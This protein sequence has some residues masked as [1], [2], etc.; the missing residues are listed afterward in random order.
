[1]PRKFLIGQLACFGDCLYA[2]TIAKQIKKD[3]PDSH[4]TWAVASKYRSILELN[5]F[6][7]AIWE[8]P[9]NNGD[10]YDD[11]WDKFEA[12]ALERKQKGEFDEIIFSQVI[13]NNLL[14]YQGT[15][16]GTI[17]AA[18]GRPITV[19]KEPVLRLSE[20]EVNN[21][22]V[23]AEKSNIKRYKHVVLFECDAG[24]GQSK[25]NLEHALKI[26]KYICAANKDVCFIIS[27]SK[28]LGDVAPQIIDASSLTYRENAELT[29]YCTL[30]VGC[31]S[32]IT[33]IST[34]DWAKK[35]P[36]VQVLDK[37]FG[38]FAGVAYDLRL[39]GLDDQNVIEV[40]DFSEKNV[41]DCIL[42]VLNGAFKEAKQKY[43]E[44]YAPSKYYQYKIISSY[45][46]R[47][48]K[49]LSA[50]RHVFEYKNAHRVMS[51][52]IL[53]RIYVTGIVRSVIKR[54]RANSQKF[55]NKERK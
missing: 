52:L 55:L 36:M 33:W 45:Y 31:C 25:M 41:A 30:L 17:L 12:Q 32:G 19:S 51:L 23:F 2:T 35:L 22:K 11:G 42:L 54:I 6:V 44:E 39:N 49:Y 4:I 37:Y 38:F 15:I 46:M 10:Y 21:V 47:N 9:I 27:S 1:M 7:D 34:S 18:Y 26:A 48:G 5:P 24:S 43:H 50:L 16:R 29:K 14:N 13:P 28:K 8:I 53:F 3:F 20:Q 40:L